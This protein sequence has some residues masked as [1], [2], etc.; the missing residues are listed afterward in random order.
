[1][2]REPERCGERAGL[3]LLER[4]GARGLVVDLGQSL[5]KISTPTRRWVHA[6]DLS[7]IP[8]PPAGDLARGREALVA[9]V[10]AALHQ[11]R[12]QAEPDAIVL[13]LPCEVSADGTVG[14]CSYPWRAGDC[15][16]SEVLAVAGLGGR[17]AYLVNDA[18]LAAIGLVEEGA[19]E[20]GTL[21]LT[22]GFGVGAALVGPG[23]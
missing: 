19:A 8:P 4:A 1:M 6:R 7:A 13:A 12:R 11:A 20:D 17:P 5:L 15:I 23:S 10:A 16:A 14:T 18:E 2:A 3:H 22:I 9:W 21:V